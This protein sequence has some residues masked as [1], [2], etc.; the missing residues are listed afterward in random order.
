MTCKLAN[1]FSNK[2]Q[3]SLDKLPTKASD[4]VSLSILLPGMLFSFIFICIGI[5]DLSF[6]NNESNLLFKEFAALEDS[7]GV[8]NSFINPCFFDVAI[9]LLGLGNIISLLTAY[10]RYKKIYFDGKTVEIIHRTPTGKKIRTKDSLKNYEGVRFRIEFLQ[11]G[12]V[13]RNKYIIELLHKDVCKVAPLYISTSGKDIRKIWE[14]YVKALK[15]PA[16]LNTDEGEVVRDFKDVDKPLSSQYKAGIINDDYDFYEPI[17]DNISY[18]RKRDK[19]VIKGHK[20]IWDAYNFVA[21]FFIIVFSAVYLILFTQLEHF[22]QKYN[23][24]G[25]FAFYIVSLALLLSAIWILFRKEK[26]VIKKQK[27]VHTYKY[28]LFSTKHDE[29][30]KKD[31]ESVEIFIN[32]FSGRRCLSIESKEKNI[33]FGKKLPLKDLQWV[34][35]LIIHEVIS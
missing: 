4:R 14:Y 19:L 34:K 24:L 27:I 31:I 9:I 28:M 32:P 29:M 2:Y 22:S 1:H 17:P 5:Y 26:I 18:V 3:L 13:S 11:F 25:V 12:L 10:L 33:T 16:I 7:S 20:I 6:S 30:N 21:W 8:Y 35:K 23:I 15:K